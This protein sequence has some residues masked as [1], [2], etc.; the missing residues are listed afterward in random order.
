MLHILLIYLCIINGDLLNTMYICDI[1]FYLLDGF[2][3]L[4]S[5][6]RNNS[7]NLVNDAKGQRKVNRLCKKSNPH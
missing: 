4:R 5:H 6:I 7:K 2:G 1:G 3:S